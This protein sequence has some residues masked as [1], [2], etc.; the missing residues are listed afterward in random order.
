LKGSSFLVRLLYK[1]SNFQLTPFYLGLK[2]DKVFSVNFG[3]I[4]QCN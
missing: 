1:E 4:F 3:M 2:R